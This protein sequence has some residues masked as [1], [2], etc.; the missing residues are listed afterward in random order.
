[1]GHEVRF[2]AAGHWLK[3]WMRSS[4]WWTLNTCWL[5]QQMPFQQHPPLMRRLQAVGVATVR[6]ASGRC[7]FLE[8]KFRAQCRGLLTT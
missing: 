2:C 4:W 3:R 6:D 8:V 7:S 5:S 1:M